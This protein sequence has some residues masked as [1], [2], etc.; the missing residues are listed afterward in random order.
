LLLKSELIVDVTIVEA[1]AS[2]VRI[3]A[4]G[5]DMTPDL[6]VAKPTAHM[7]PHLHDLE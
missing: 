4:A 3:V 7:S 6:R 2:A 5:P 1:A